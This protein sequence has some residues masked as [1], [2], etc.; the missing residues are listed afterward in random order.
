M[1]NLKLFYN[2]KQVELDATN[3]E[4]QKFYNIGHEKLWC[5]NTDYKEA[6]NIC[7]TYLLCNSSYLCGVMRFV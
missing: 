1:C 7:S 5:K 2:H 6:A 3:H 4:A